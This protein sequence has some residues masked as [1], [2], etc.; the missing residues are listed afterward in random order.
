VE[1]SQKVKQN[2]MSSSSLSSSGGESL[3][4]PYRKRPYDD[5]D[6]P[7]PPHYRIQTDYASYNPQEATTT[8]TTT[9]TTARAD[10]HNDAQEEDEDDDDDT[11]VLGL[12]AVVPEEEDTN[13]ISIWDASGTIRHFSSIP[14]PQGKKQHV[15]V[16]NL[17]FST[18][19]NILVDDFCNPLLGRSGEPWIARR[20]MFLWLGYSSFARSQ[21]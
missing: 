16:S 11:G 15:H 17:C 20:R 21:L 9:T 14:P 13:F 1:Q 6:H 12:V 10:E 3:K 8:T 19:G 7:P 4:P 18:H 2:N 5:G